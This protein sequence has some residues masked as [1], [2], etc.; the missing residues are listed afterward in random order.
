MTSDESSPSSDNRVFLITGA[1]TG[2]GAATAIEASKRGFR[3]ALTS[4][5]EDKLSEL[6][7]RCGGSGRALAV[8][9]DVQD[10]ESQKSMVDR[11]LAEFGQIDVVFANAGGSFGGAFVGGDDTPEEWQQMVQ[12][13]VFGVAATARLTLP[14]LIENNGQLILCGSVAGRIA[15]GSLYSA[16]KWAV[17]GMAESIRKKV[18]EHGVR[19]TLIGPGRVDTPFWDSPQ[20]QG[21][22]RDIDIAECVVWAA[23]QPKHVDVNEILVRPVGQTI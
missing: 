3:V 18:T 5:S 11:V 14:N 10:W 7:V 9:C 21:A 19:V 17:T 22:L 16:T 15:T 8:A 2:I 20:S 4:R 23:T 13:N 1:S 12:T 6:A